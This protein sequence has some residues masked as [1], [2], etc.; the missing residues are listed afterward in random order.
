MET[1]DGEKR[2]GKESHL[3]DSAEH[4]REVL[5]PLQPLH[6]AAPRVSACTRRRLTHAEVC[7]A[8]RRR[9]RRKRSVHTVERE[10]CTRRR[11]RD[12]VCAPPGTSR[13]DRPPSCEI[14]KPVIGE[15]PSVLSAPRVVLCQD[16]RCTAHAHAQGRAELTRGVVQNTS[17]SRAHLSFPRR[18]IRR[19]GATGAL[20][21]FCRIQQG[22]CLGSIL[23]RWNGGLVSG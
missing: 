14:S 23:F 22:L 19:P 17:T 11:R 12:T 10:A 18:V 7:S 2:E 5:T 15:L 21:S 16:R 9:K 6:P 3:V 20:G 1:E 4:D 8:D 13:Q